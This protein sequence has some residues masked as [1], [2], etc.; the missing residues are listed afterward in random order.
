MIDWLVVCVRWLAVH[1]HFSTGIDWQVDTLKLIGLGANAQRWLAGMLLMVTDSN[2]IALVQKELEDLSDYSRLFDFSL[3]TERSLLINLLKE[4]QQRS[5]HGS[6]Y[7]YTTTMGITG[8]CRFFL[9]IAKCIDPIS[10]LCEQT[11]LLQW[12]VARTSS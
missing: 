5:A 7:V 11:S 2:Q 1:P 8:S 10:V 4:A 12:I 9:Y 3:T 6:H